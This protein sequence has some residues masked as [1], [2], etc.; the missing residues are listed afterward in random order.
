MVCQIEGLNSVIECGGAIVGS[1]RSVSQ[2]V[3]VDS[4]LWSIVVDVGGECSLLG[5]FASSTSLLAAMTSAA[6]LSLGRSVSARTTIG[7]ALL[8]LLLLLGELGVSWLALYSAKLVGLKALTTS[9]RGRAFLLER[10]CGGLDNP[11][12]LQVLDF[13][14]GCL[15]ENLSYDLH[16]RRELAE[17]DH[18]LHWGRELKASIFEIG[19]VAKQLHNGRSGMGASRNVGGEEPTKLSIGQADT[20][21]AEVLLQVVPDLLYSSKLRDGDLDQGG[22]VQGDITEC[23]LGIVVPVLSVIMAIS[24]LSG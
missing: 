15:A 22:E 3:R 5:S 20:G 23:S 12:R 16:S 17:D 21:G 18:C 6:S 14:W 11:I 10:E 2:G 1:T 9:V 7:P 13:I 4:G 19:E 24:R 8:L